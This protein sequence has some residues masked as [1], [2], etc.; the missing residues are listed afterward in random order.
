MLRGDVVGFAGIGRQVVKFDGRLRIFEKVSPNRFPVPLQH[1]GFP[2]LLVEF[3]IEMG[4]DDLSGGIAQQG[5]G[6]GYAVR[7]A[8]RRHSGQCRKGG[9]Y[10]LK[11]RNQAAVDPRG[12]FCLK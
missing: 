7:E 2:S 8:R 1:S 4:M 10:I 3:P 9:Q 6:K 12:K 5:G 11:S